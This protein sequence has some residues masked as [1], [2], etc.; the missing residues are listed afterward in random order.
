M[1][2]EYVT[3]GQLARMMGVKPRWVYGHISG[4]VNN[5]KDG[6]TW[7]KSVLRSILDRKSGENASY[8]LKQ[9]EAN[10]GRGDLPNGCPYLCQEAMRFLWAGGDDASRDHRWHEARRLTYDS[11]PLAQVGT[12]LH[13]GGAMQL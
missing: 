5:F 7:Q 10:H 2:H 12:P 3:V 1:E 4:I 9:N 11:G 13:V 8:S 6:V